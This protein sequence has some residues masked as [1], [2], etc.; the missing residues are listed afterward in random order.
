MQKKLPDRKRLQVKSADESF[1]KDLNEEHF[2]DDMIADTIDAYCMSRGIKP[3]IGVPYINYD[4]TV[5][6]AVQLYDPLFH[7]YA[8]IAW[9]R[10]GNT[11]QSF[12]TSCYLDFNRLRKWRE[13]YPEFNEACVLCVQWRELFW[14]NRLKNA[15]DPVELKKAIVATR[16]FYSDHWRVAEVEI[17]KNRLTA[18]LTLNQNNYGLSAP[19]LAE[20]MSVDQLLKLMDLQ[21]RVVNR[22]IEMSPDEYKIIK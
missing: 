21:E 6:G 20:K 5:E 2:S 9:G 7:P 15:T 14:E 10:A 13:K 1:I 12:A 22:K 17:A 11:L 18:K 4:E 8:V 16:N 3:I 19:E